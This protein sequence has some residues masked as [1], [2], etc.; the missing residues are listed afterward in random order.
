MAI[1]LMISFAVPF[2]IILL[3]YQNE[4]KSW[5]TPFPS[6]HP[7][8]RL[9]F[10]FPSPFPILIEEMRVE[11]RQVPG[12]LLMLF[13]LTSPSPFPFPSIKEVNFLSSSF[14][15]WNRPPSAFPLA[16]MFCSYLMV[17]VCW[18]KLCNLTAKLNGPPSPS[19]CQGTKKNFSRIF[20]SD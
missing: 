15:L 18:N 5:I 12:L 4:R 2:K 13:H 3:L 7:T 9:N 11:F 8:I 20:P 1:E 16:L 6:G 14:F 17:E 10:F 19:F